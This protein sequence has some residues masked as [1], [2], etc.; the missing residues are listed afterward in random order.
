MVTSPVRMQLDPRTGSS[1]EYF[2][3]GTAS[4]ASISAM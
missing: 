1:A 4:V 2:D 3:A